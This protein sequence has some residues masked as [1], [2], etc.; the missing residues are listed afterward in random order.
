MYRATE[1]KLDRDVAF[2]RRS[3]HSKKSDSPAP[4]ACQDASAT[5]G[6]SSDSR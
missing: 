3:V 1:T 4:G 2:L 5:R 6:C